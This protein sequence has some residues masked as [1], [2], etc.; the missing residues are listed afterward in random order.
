MAQR[1]I[2]AVAA[3]EETQCF[4]KAIVAAVWAMARRTIKAVAAARQTIQ[5]AKAMVVAQCF[6][7]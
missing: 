7:R 3:A 2:K 1:T 5:Q 4:I 6:I